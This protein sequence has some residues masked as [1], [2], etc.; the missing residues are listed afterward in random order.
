[1]LILLTACCRRIAWPLQRHEDIYLGLAALP[2][3]VWSLTWG[4]FSA[5]TQRGDSWPFPW[6]PLLNPLDL[7]VAAALAALLYWLQRVRSIAHLAEYVESNLV[8]LQSGL[9]A[10]VFIWLNSILA[11]T[12][13]FWGGVPFNA[14]AMFRSNLVQTSYTLFWSLLA[15]CIMVV[16]VRRSLRSVWMVG[17]GLLGLVVGKLF[18]VDLASHGTVERIVSFVAVGL[19]LLVIGWFAPV[20]PRVTDFKKA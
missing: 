9:A 20:P 5:L 15:L 18:L 4:M 3:A 12:L 10:A 6:L 11:R 1:L 13:H 8:L 17:A 14:H 16:A 2:L 7:A 19:L